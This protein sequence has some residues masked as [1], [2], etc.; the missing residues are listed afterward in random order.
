MEIDM[1]RDY[2]ESRTGIDKGGQDTTRHLLGALYDAAVEAVSPYGTVLG[3]VDYLR[4]IFVEG[5]FRK[6]YVAAIGKSAYGMARAIEETLSDILTGG[7][8]ITK[9]GHTDVHPLQ[10]I[11]VFEAAHPTPD[12]SGQE[13]TRELLGL[14]RGLDEQTLLLCLISGGG[15]ALFVCPAGGVSLMDKR[16][17]TDMLLRAGANIAE[18][19]AV[20]KHLS[21]VKGGQFARMTYPARVVSLIIS[22]CV[23][24]S[25]DVIASGPTTADTTTFADALDVLTKYDL[26]HQLSP[27]VVNHLLEGQRGF[28]PDTPKDGDTIVKGVENIIVANNLRALN[29]ARSKAAL[30]GIDA[31]ILTDSLTGEARTAAKWLASQIGQ[32]RHSTRDMC[33][34]SGGET[35]VSVRGSGIGGRNMELALAFAIEVEG[36]DGVTLLSAGTDG[37][38]CVDD[39]AGAI[40]NGYTTMRARKMGLDP[41]QYLN[42]ND[43]YNFFKHLGDLFITG[44][45]Q[46]NVMDIQLIR[47]CR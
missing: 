25:L 8:A 15:S 1:T 5:G 36:L 26:T 10:K 6:L 47:L 27:S 33:L 44:P 40:V 4:R 17:T 3:H 23:G 34:I 13:A 31:H 21:L 37:T 20:R 12:E 42:N 41:I 2:D 7:V 46:T 24:D 19:N 11:R 45:T 35:T 43:S 14:T 30:M 16:T 29:A 9:Y 39:A 32:P 28:Q 38:D 18:L 22:D